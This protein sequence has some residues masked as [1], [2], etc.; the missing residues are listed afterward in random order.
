MRVQSIDH[1]HTSQ[2]LNAAARFY[3]RIYSN[4]AVQPTGIVDEL[5]NAAHAADGDLN[6]QE[7]AEALDT[8][9]LGV[10]VDTDGCHNIAV[11]D[12]ELPI[13]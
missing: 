13:H 2:V 4:S 7:I 9:E 1:Q 3:V 8:P 12:A 10:S 6:G 11:D 5:L